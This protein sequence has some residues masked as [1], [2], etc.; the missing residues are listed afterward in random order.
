MQ[1]NLRTRQGQLIHRLNGDQIVTLNQ[2]HQIIHLFKII[3]ILDKFK[4]FEDH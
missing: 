3:K 2:N 1:K 4:I